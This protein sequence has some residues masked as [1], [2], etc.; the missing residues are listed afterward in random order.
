MMISLFYILL[1]I[2]RIIKQCYILWVWVHMEHWII[3]CTFI[4]SALCLNIVYLY[5]PFKLDILSEG[6]LYFSLYNH[7]H[8]WTI[9][10][11][12]TF[13]SDYTHEMRWPIAP[14]I[15]P[16]S[17]TFIINISTIS[18]SSRILAKLVDLTV[19]LFYVLCMLFCCICSQWA[20]SS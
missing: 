20:Q 18:F 4:I 1:V 15:P 6:I 11:W 10:F 2:T 9:I 17:T 8:W 19:L 16:V 13:D 5:L 14:H 7:M 12:K 3:S